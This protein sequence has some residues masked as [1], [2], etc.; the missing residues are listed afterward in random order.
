MK[1]NCSISSFIF[2]VKAFS[3]NRPLGMDASN[4]S[5]SIL[6]SNLKFSEFF[7]FVSIISIWEVDL[8]TKF[9]SLEM[10]SYSFKSILGSSY[11]DFIS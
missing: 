10:S 2:L 5:K 9:S 8:N 6:L 4:K 1:D 3:F 11:S 7:S